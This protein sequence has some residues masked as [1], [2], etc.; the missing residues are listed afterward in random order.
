[1][2]A[3]KLLYAKELRLILWIFYYDGS[4]AGEVLLVLLLSIE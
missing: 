2:A 1:M 3:S 4:T